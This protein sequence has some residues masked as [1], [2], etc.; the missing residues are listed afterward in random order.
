MNNNKNKLYKSGCRQQANNKGATTPS[1]NDKY[2][3][4]NNMEQVN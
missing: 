1:P 2:G 4:N 3:N